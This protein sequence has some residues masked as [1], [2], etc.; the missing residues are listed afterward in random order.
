MF[1]G[2]GKLRAGSF[3][4]WVLRKPNMIFVYFHSI[5]RTTGSETKLSKKGPERKEVEAQT[6]QNDKKQA[7]PEVCQRLHGEKHISKISRNAESVGDFVLQSLPE[8]R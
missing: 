5:R 2:L 7:L 8:H 4:K 3:E 6:S 1:V